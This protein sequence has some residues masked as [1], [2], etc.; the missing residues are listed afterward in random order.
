MCLDFEGL[1][2]SPMWSFIWKS[3]SISSWNK[4]PHSVYTKTS[5]YTSLRNG[6]PR[7]SPNPFCCSAQTLTIKWLTRCHR[8]SPQTHPALANL[9]HCCPSTPA[10]WVDSKQCLQISSAQL[11]LSVVLLNKIWNSQI[12]PN[13]GKTKRWFNSPEMETSQNHPNHSPVWAEWRIGSTSEQMS[14]THTKLHKIHIR[15]APKSW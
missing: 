14:I 15:T 7:S 11:V 3:D 4:P 5:I 2:L 10:P 13:I 1:H 6:T 12:F 9:H 8:P